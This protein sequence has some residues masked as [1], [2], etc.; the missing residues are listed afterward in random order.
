VQGTAPHRYYIS[1]TAGDGV[2][3][4]SKC[5]LQLRVAAIDTNPAK[6]Y[7]YGRNTT[8]ESW[9][10]LYSTTYS[11]TGIYTINTTTN[12]CRFYIV[13]YKTHIMILRNQK[14]IYVV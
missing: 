12:T 5:V 8:D 7:I 14:V 9:Q 10:T 4:F 11:S 1:S 3:I 6:F 13:H 2:N